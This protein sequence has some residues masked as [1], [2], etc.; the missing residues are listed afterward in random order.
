MRVVFVALCSLAC[1]FGSLFVVVAQTPDWIAVDYTD[2]VDGRRLSHSG[3]AV[4]TLLARL[5]GRPLP[6]GSDRPG[7]ALTHVLL[8]P[9]LEP[10][11]FVLSDT[12]DALDPARVRAV[13]WVDLGALWLPGERQ[14]AWV[15][16]LRSRQYVVE[17]DGS[18][19]LRIALPAD[20]GPGYAAGRGAPKAASAEEAEAAYRRAWPVLR[21]IFA[22]E[23][24]R[25]GQGT[26]APPLE[27]TSYVYRHA[28]EQT[29]FALGREPF[30]T[31]VDSTAPDGTR[32]AL[33]L[34]AWQR[35]LDSGLQL[36]GARLEADG[37]LR[38]FGSQSARPTTMLG[39]PISLA[40]MAVAHRAIFHGG[41]AEPYMSLDRGFS[42]QAAIVNYGGR[43]RDTRMGLVSLLCD[44]RFKTF[45]LGLGI[46]E[47]ADL[48]QSLR[49]VIRNFQTHIERFSANKDSARVGAQQTR[50]WFYPD[51]VDLTVSAEGDVLAMRRPRMAA[52]SERVEQDGGTA[53]SVPPWTQATVSG[54]NADYDRL[55]A[56][57]PELAD[58]DQVVRLLSLFTWL[59]QARLEGLPVPDLDV[60]LTT[61][62][63]ALATPRAY[64]QLLTFTAL[65]RAGAET[66]VDVF[67][68]VPFGEALERLNPTA[69]PGPALARLERAI[70]ALDPSHPQSGEF[71]STL[72][73]RDRSQLSASGADQLAF[74]AERLRMHRTVLETPDDDVRRRVA[75]RI[76]A[77]EGIRVFSVAIGGLDLDMKSAVSRARGRKLGMGAAPGMATVLP[78]SLGLALSGRPGSAGPPS[79]WSRDPAGLPTARVPS[80][81]SKAR[82][83][84]HQRG[85]EATRIQTLYASSSIDA[86]LR[87]LRYDDNGN[88]ETMLRYDDGRRIHYRWV[89][90]A[91]GRMF[92]AEL[93]LA[94]LP[95]DTFSAMPERVPEG[96]TIFQVQDRVGA[97]RIPV[98]L[99]ARPNADVP[100]QIEATLPRAELQRLI[101]GHSADFAAGR[102]LGGLTTFPPQLGTVSTMMLLQQFRQSVEPWD[103]TATIAFG[104]TRADILARSLNE[105]WG[106]D[107]SYAS[108]VGTHPLRSVARWEAMGTLSGPV[109]L[110][111]LAGHSNGHD[112]L[113]EIREVW[114]AGPVLSAMPK[115]GAPRMTVIVADEPPAVLARRL[116]RFAADP[117]YAGHALAIWSLAG[118][119][120]R[121]LPARWLDADRL[122]AIGIGS[123]T[124]VSRRRFEQALK[125]LSDAVQQSSSGAIRPEELPG[126]LLWYY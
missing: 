23:R 83:L 97:D 54:V 31:R 78:A 46:R 99:Q 114:K 49:E 42:P 63:P 33:D 15:E 94:T 6:A 52:A 77:G 85:V 37:T 93:L 19:R 43:L 82:G 69:S 2:L 115:G 74:A 20:N 120:R 53:R 117:A 71:L 18:G 90:D 57:F 88:L 70:A 34:A 14:P 122:L 9:L 44:I 107:G 62:L 36:E 118:P 10:Y 7:D 68:R 41:L 61:E 21:H 92:R 48:R 45:S 8:D 104:E 100:Q 26:D 60:L 98:R 67:D 124:I 89:A 110:V 72:T 81:G 27:V 40:D 91:S 29:Q 73:G 108:V 96:L 87:E 58:L 24:A 111:Y 79:S 84:E 102:P 47:G 76:Q 1:W 59:Q 39:Q 116:T 11:A 28:P 64:P 113:K 75:P 103:E 95:P 35:F 86:R 101:L 4:E 105:W 66:A 106:D 3:E 30:V 38:L 65:P 126:P 121:D 56:F 22:A 12:L 109:S 5:Q 123:E 119:L 50:L 13:A 55:A 17:S 125:T 112:R 80:H 25:L 51:T 16:L 32:P